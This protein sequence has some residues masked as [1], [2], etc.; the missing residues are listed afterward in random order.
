MV[1]GPFPG[2]NLP[3]TGNVH[4]LGRYRVLTHATR[5][6]LELPMLQWFLLLQRF[7]RVCR[8]R[9]PEKTVNRLVAG[10]NPA[11]GA[12][13]K[14]VRCFLIIFSAF[15]QPR[16][17]F[18]TG[19]SRFHLFHGG[20]GKSLPVNCIRRKDPHCTVDR[21][22]PCRPPCEGHGRIVMRHKP[23]MDANQ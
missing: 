19:R 13:A 15:C 6:I 9:Q 2:K 21:S 7:A 11:R 1:R 17:G 14:F 5:I 12:I 4:A 10:S 20:A 23:E 16:D 22:S 3:V 18:D 8:R